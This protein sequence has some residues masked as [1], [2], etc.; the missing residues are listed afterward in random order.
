VITLADQ[1]VIEQEAIIVNRR[2]GAPT[3]LQVTAVT[4][5]SI[6]LSWQHNGE[7]ED[8]FR[9]YNAAVEQ[10]LAEF[11]RD[12]TGGTI[13]NL[14]CNITYTLYLVAYN[15]VGLSERSNTIEQALACP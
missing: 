3:N 15:Q 6:S 7:N 1:E 11:P 12:A 13:S 5:T 10:V 8:G 4:T 14:T 2:P 9:A